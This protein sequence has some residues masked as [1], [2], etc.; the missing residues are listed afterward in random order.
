[1][2]SALTRRQREGSLSPEQVAKALRAFRFDWN[3]QFRVVDLDQPLAELAGQLLARHPLRAYDAVQMASALRIETARTL[4]TDRDTGS[5]LAVARGLTLLETGLPPSDPYVCETTIG[6]PPDERWYT[7]TFQSD[8][9]GV[10]SVHAAPT[11]WPD[12]PEPMPPSF[13]GGN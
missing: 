2:T 12:A 4:Q 7:V 6:S 3:T 13:A 10:W 11:Q 9:P 5:I 8:E 1:M